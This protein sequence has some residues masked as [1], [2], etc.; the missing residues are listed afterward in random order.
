M[1]HE[2]ELLVSYAKTL[3]GEHVTP[4]AMGE[5][6]KSFVEKGS[7][8]LESVAKIEGQVVEVTRMIEKEKA[9]A[10]LKKGET[11]GQVIMV[12]VATEDCAVDLNLTYSMFV[13]NIMWN[14][15]DTYIS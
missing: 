11:E 8:N 5:F 15:T 3:N 12:V 14:V 7:E 2:S 9:K 1:D 4:T 10:A 13:C 6:L